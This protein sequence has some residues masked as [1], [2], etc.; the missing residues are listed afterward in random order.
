MKRTMERSPQRIG[1]RFFENI[2]SISSL[3]APDGTM[4]GKVSI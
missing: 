2:G 4:L 1:D 3:D